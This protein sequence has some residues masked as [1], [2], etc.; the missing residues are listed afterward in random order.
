V[1]EPQDVVALVLFFSGPGAGFFTGQALYLN[2]G[3]TATP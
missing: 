2:G 1:A 3:L